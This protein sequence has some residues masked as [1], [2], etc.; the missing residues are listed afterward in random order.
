MID[1]KLQVQ[2]NRLW[3][4]IQKRDEK[5]AGLN[6]RIAELE[7]TLAVKDNLLNKLP[8]DITKA[9]QRAI[10]NVR[11]IP[12]HGSI[13]SNELIVEVKSSKNEKPF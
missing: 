3:R 1:S 11:M 6:K 2:F 7:H 9:V 10:C 12:V 13:S 4:K 5:I 8:T